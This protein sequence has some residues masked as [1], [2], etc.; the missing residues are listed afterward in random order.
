MKNTWPYIVGKARRSRTCV[1]VIGIAALQGNVLVTA[2]GSGS[3]GGNPGTS[4][5][6]QT[7]EAAATPLASATIVRATRTAPRVNATWV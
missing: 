6:G 1:L 4:V 5:A 7:M 2:C 3:A